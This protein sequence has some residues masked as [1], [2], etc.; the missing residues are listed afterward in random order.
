MLKKM[1]QIYEKVMIEKVEKI[2]ETESQGDELLGD[3]NPKFFEEVTHL[4]EAKERIRASDIYVGSN[5]NYF[6]TF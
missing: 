1:V 5:F 6:S 4:K 2:E 3:L